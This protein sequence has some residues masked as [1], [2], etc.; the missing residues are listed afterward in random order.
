MIDPN[1][2]LMVED[3]RL[4]PSS[5]RAPL[6]KL[7]AEEAA[8]R[9][10]RNP[11]EVPKSVSKWKTLIIYRKWATRHNYEIAPLRIS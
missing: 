1:L 3:D 9:G 4:L 8:A 7:R 2:V 11:R 10:D 6:E 5:S